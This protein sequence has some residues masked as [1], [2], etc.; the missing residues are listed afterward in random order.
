MERPRGLALAIYLVGGTLTILPVLDAWMAVTPVHMDDVR[1]RFGAAGLAANSLVLPS[2]GLLLLL[3]TSLVYGHTAL[4]RIVGIVALVGALVFCVGIVFF[5]LDAVQTR[6]DVRPAMSGSFLLASSSA[7]VKML[8]AALTFSAVGLAGVHGMRA[9]ESPRPTP[10][11]VG[12]NHVS[13]S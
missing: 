7:V 12:L 4:R 9:K 13:R 6:P 11:L 5:V 2:V 8:I 10:P 3:A 1:W